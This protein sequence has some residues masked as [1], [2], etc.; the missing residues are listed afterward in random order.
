MTVDQRVENLLVRIW[1]GINLDKVVFQEGHITYHHLCN[2]DQNA[3]PQF[4]TKLSQAADDNYK[5]PCLEDFD[6]QDE[7]EGEEE[8]PLPIPGPSGT[9]TRS[10][11][12]TG[13]QTCA[14]PI[15]TILY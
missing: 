2:I 3:N 12:V 7:E 15:S 8:N 11:K 4:Y 13:V 9:H 1:S 5:P 6:S 14:L 10:S